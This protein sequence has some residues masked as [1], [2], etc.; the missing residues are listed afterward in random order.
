MKEITDR[1][2]AVAR[3]KAKKT[4]SAEDLETIMALLRSE[5][6]CPWDREQ[7]H[8]SIRRN[9][10]EETY[11]A[12][13]AIDSHDAALLQEE[14]GDVLLQVFF[15]ARIS[16]E[17]GEF[18]LADVYTGECLKMIE[19][20][21]HIFGE[22]RVDG[23]EDVLNNWEA[24]KREK[25]GQSTLGETLD[26]V[27]RSLPSLMRAEK[28]AHKARKAGEFRDED[29][30]GALGDRELAERLFAL[31]AEADRRGLDAEKLLYDQCEFF[32]EQIKKIDE[33]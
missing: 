7:T 27:S 8:E 12:V 32:I 13:E 17:A 20:H 33:K 15:H 14:L 2:E 10:I 22:V 30:L 9:F 1:T 4:F 25:K 31:A 5:G 24:I 3:L 26:G 23:S 21:P 19:R 28:L 11:E 18:S 16:E 29:A 6:G